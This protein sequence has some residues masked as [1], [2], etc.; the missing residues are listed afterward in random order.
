MD[1]ASRSIKTFAS[2]VSSYVAFCDQRHI[3]AKKDMPATEDEVARW[4]GLLKTASTGKV[5]KAALKKAHLVAPQPIL[6]ETD[7]ISSV[8][9]GLGADR[10]PPAEKPSYD[11]AMVRRA[12]S[13]RDGGVVVG[14]EKAPCGI[15]WR[16]LPVGGPPLV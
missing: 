12:P 5:Y 16:H 15:I 14:K 3:G 11:H 2:G 13:C 10:P 8:I 6:F 1:S 4:L 9:Q 7:R